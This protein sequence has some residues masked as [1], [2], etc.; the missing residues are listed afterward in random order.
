MKEPTLELTRRKSAGA[1]NRLM[2]FKLV[3]HPLNSSS[4]VLNSS[5]CSTKLKRSHL[6]RQLATAHLRHHYIGDQ[7][8]NRVAMAMAEL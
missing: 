5:H 7:Q 4:S 3:S 2:L 6:L 1:K 8:I